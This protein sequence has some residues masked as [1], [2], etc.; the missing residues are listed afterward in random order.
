MPE[1]I[2]KIRTDK[3][4]CLIDY[5]A[6]ANRPS[7]LKNPN[8]ITFT[9]AVSAQYDGSSPVTVNI[10]ESYD[11]EE[12][13]DVRTG[14]DGT[15]YDTAGDA[16]RGQASSLYDQY[17]S[18]RDDLSDVVTYP[19]IVNP[20][21]QENFNYLGLNNISPTF[22]DGGFHF[23]TSG[24]N[25]SSIWFNVQGLVLGHNYKL[26]FDVVEDA[27]YK[28][29]IGDH[30]IN[31]AVGKQ[32]YEFAANSS[33]LAMRMIIY[34][35]ET[36]FKVTNSELVDLDEKATLL[37]EL[38]AKQAEKELQEQIDQKITKEELKDV[39][40]FSGQSTNPLVEDNYRY[41]G[42]NSISLIFFGQGFTISTSG[43]NDT[44]LWFDIK[45]L[46]V[47]HS[48]SISFNVTF[49]EL[50][51]VRISD[52][53]QNNVSGNFEH[54]FTAENSRQSI[55]LGVWYTNT[56]ITVD[57]V[58]LVDLDEKTHLVSNY[59]YKGKKGVRFG[60][61]I[62][63]QADF[64]E[65]GKLEG[66]GWSALVKEYF[67][68]S[69]IVNC[70]IGGSTISGDSVT[71]AMWTDERINALPEDSDFVLFMGGTNDWMQNKPLGDLDSVDTSTFH[72]ALN[73][74]A[75][76]L[77]ARFPDAV[78]IWMCNVYG[79]KINSGEENGSGLT[80]Y[81]YSRAFIESADMNG[82]AALDMFKSWTKHNCEQYL[83][84]ED[85][86]TTFIHPNKKGG[87]KMAGIII[88]G[89]KENEP[90]II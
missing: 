12:L 21:A 46:V 31:N 90:I 38:R 20:F 50:F 47:G 19:E 22:E 54:Q 72:G 5:N 88:H 58:K 48:Y 77:S 14:W 89:M 55:N 78:I 61:S 63:A 16:V 52:F 44:N 59:W 56:T 9:G 26:S 18:L 49:G 23:V 64:W 53:K 40:S 8:A 82:F 30:V 51:Y 42:T 70:G 10:P 11:S 80:L 28:I 33:D 67:G 4:D 7:S 13:I 60:D 68:C 73:V 34:Y 3:G 65:E 24:I 85:D 29:L 87:M 43:V 6:L 74:I 66:S 2:K 37:E 71:N 41:T 62:T 27:I 57:D 35:T 81:D 69:D 15:E 39:I 17:T 86:G 76:K 1:Y 36:N 83:N 45:N 79:K 84:S 75:Q 25:D 32:S